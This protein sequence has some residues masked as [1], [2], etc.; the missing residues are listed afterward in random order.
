V[1]KDERETASEP[2]SGRDASYTTDKQRSM[3]K[4]EAER[5]VKNL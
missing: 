3:M 2:Q 5:G 1:R 4:K